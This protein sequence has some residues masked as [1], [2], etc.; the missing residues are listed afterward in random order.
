ME[1]FLYQSTLTILHYIPE[2]TFCGELG[3]NGN[4]NECKSL[5]EKLEAIRECERRNSECRFLFC[6]P[7]FMKSGLAFIICKKT[8]SIL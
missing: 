5:I 8:S 4:L 3:Q 2:S 1:M 7:K 6:M